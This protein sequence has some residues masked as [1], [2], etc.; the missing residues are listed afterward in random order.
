[1]AENF[2]SKLF[3][4]L[5]LLLA[6]IIE[7]FQTPEGRRELLRRIGWRPENIDQFPAVELAAGIT[8]CCSRTMRSS[9]L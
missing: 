5:Q 9:S 4:E 1:V 7:G 6:P 2:Q 3:A 8:T